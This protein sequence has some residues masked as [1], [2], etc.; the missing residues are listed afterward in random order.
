MPA[1]PKA[2]PKTTLAVSRPTERLELARGGG[3][4]LLGGGVTCEDLRRHRVHHLVGALRRQDGCDEELIGAA[5]PKLAVGVGVS[6][7]QRIDQALGPRCEL[8]FALA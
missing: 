5:M 1:T 7:E 8:G 6:R 4:E 3:G 2:L